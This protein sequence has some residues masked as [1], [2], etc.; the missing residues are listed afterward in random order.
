MLLA[1][2]ATANRVLPPR[3]IAIAPKRLTPNRFSLS[4]YGDPSAEIDDLLPSI[5]DLGILVALVVAP[6]PRPG[7][8]EVVSG[9]RRLACARALNF[10][11]VPCEV[12]PLPLGP[13]RRRAVLEY[14]RQRRKSF[15]QLMRE[16]DALEELWSAEASSRR[17]ANL[18]RGRTDSAECRNSDDRGAIPDSND[19]AGNEDAREQRVDR[20]RTDTAI[21]R[22][23]GIGGKDLYRQARAIWRLAR[24]G[25]V[26][27]QSGI[28]ELDAGTKSIHAAYKDLRRRDRYSADFRPTPYDVWLFRHDRA[29]GIPH[30]GAIPPGIVAHTLHYF[31]LPDA[32][33]VDPMAGGGTTL[34]VCQSMGRRCLAY[35]LNPARPEIRPHDIRH[36]FP[37]EAAGCDLIFCD[38]PYHTMLARQYASDSIA[39]APLSEWIAFLHELTSHAFATLRPG[40]CLALLLAPQT[41]K[42]LPPGFGYLDHAF[43]GYV[44]ALRA[45]FLPER[46]ISCPMDGA[47]LPQ[48]VRRARTEGRLLGQVRDLLVMR[49]TSRSR[50]C[51]AEDILFMNGRIDC[52]SAKTGNGIEV[53]AQA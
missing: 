24:S 14:N 41:E 27:A 5:R 10:A 16:A 40:G 4:I 30:P 44:A 50:D 28:A 47:Y 26:R 21:G 25:D 13:E 19:D 11:Q 35:D 15:S 31:T 42:D 9:H 36:G 34:D 32:L 12:R 23:L 46:R 37:T 38:P 18:R 1:M 45:G 3:T 7:T 52:G 43:L 39:T 51:R 8:W 6:G 49:K 53:A 48:H 22:Q 33:V 17:L 2:Q 29:F 20:G